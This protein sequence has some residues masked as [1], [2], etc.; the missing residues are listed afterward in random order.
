MRHLKHYTNIVLV[1]VLLITATS[2]E[3]LLFDQRSRVY[4]GPPVVE[5][6]PLDMTQNEGSGQIQVQ[7]QLIGEQRSEATN[8]AFAVDD[9]ATTATPDDYTVVT[10]SPVTIPANSSETTITVDLNGSGIPAGEFRQLTLRLDGGGDVEPAEN[11]RFF[12]LS[13]AGQ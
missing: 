9:S 10:A 2:C 11:L 1:A 4:D 12:D 13:I 3:D 5:F 7:V 6:F 8:V